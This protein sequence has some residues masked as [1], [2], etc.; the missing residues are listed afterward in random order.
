VTELVK[1]RKVSGEEV[2]KTTCYLCHGGCIL[3]AH[4]KDGKLLYLEGDPDGPHNRGS[5][6]EKAIATPQYLYHPSRIKYPYKRVGK[7]GE[8]KWERISWDEAM[9]TIVEKLRYYK[10]KYGGEYICYLWGTGRVN[11]CVPFKEFFNVIIGSPNGMGIGHICLSKTRMPAVA[12]TT[13]KMPPPPGMAVNRDFEGA[14]TIVGWGD[15]IID[16]RND[17]M[18]HGG[19]RIADAIKR[20]AKIIA[21][22]PV[23]TRLAQKAYHWLQIRPGTDIALALAWQHVIIHENLYDRDFVEKWTNGPFLIRTDTSKL[24]RP[25]DLENGNSSTDF[26][27]WDS[28]GGSAQVWSN[29][30]V[31]Y[32]NPDIKPA[33][34]G[35]YNVTMSDGQKVKCKTV[36]QTMKENV[37][38][39]TPEK[40]STI[41]WIPAEKIR[42]AA[43]TYATN[44]P[45]CIEWGVSMSHCTRSTATNQAIYQL[46]A[47]TGSL[48]IKGGNPFWLFPGYKSCGLGEREGMGLTPEQEAKRITGGFIFSANPELTV[49]PSAWQPGAWKAIA[50]GDPYQPKMIF[51]CDSNPLCGHEKPDRYPYQALKDKLEFTVWL[52][53]QWTPSNQY[54][55]IILPVSTPFERDWVSNSPEV[56]I[57]AGKAIIDPVGECRSDFDIFRELTRR[58]GHPDMWPWETEAELGDWQLEDIGITFKELC[59]TCFIPIPE[60]WKKY[61]TGLLL[62]DNKPGFPTVS[63]KCELYP[64]L[65]EAYGLEPLPKFSLP[66]QS[67]EGNPELAK[68][69]PL[70]LITGSRELNYPYFHSQYRHIPRL[71]EMQPFPIILIHPDTANESGIEHGNWVWIETKFGKS[72]F[73]AT[74]S[75][76]IHP[77]IVS[78]THSWFYPELPP[79]YRVFDSS[80]NVLVS[81]DPEHSDPATGTTELRGLLCKIY[82]AAGPPEGVA[83]PIE[84]GV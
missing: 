26:V 60:R 29:E 9:E 68:K 48:D 53:M 21:I 66:M 28:A 37:E 16:S 75:E 70:I 5:I 20:G 6:C 46:E 8:G 7:K 62:P 44:K 77:K 10:E 52:D 31:D 24:V 18:G 58:M 40:A 55:D 71:R 69:Y 74:V 59:K 47:I 30:K 50:T 41:T 15:T 38:E 11:D 39:W 65:L 49:A 17:Y 82:K 12:L 25:S 81:P 36:W 83:D 23:Y 54:A 14:Q 2:I 51:A 19:T 1:V 32:E 43:I 61:E 80:A 33:L 34:E 76:R 63:G 78:C 13:G 72:R 35:E 84:G 56:G 79:D 22:D 45:S 42:D 27:V 64:S 4:V 3:I 57:F 67:Y 73:K